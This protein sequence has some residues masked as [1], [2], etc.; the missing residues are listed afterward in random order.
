MTR[1]KRF[2]RRECPLC[3]IGPPLTK[4]NSCQHLL[5][6]CIV[7][8]GLLTSLHTAVQAICLYACSTV[9]GTRHAVRPSAY[10]KYLNNCMHS[11]PHAPCDVRPRIPVK[12]VLHTHQLLPYRDPGNPWLLT[13]SK[14]CLN[15]INYSSE[16]VV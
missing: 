10:H 9:P 11:R 13:W 12:L 6:L 5:H 14:G 4:R 8:R 2:L 1:V 3:D 7:P 16:Y 15:S